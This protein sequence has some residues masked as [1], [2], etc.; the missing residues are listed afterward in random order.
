M[1]DIAKVSEVAIAN[2]AK[3]STV[4]IANV[5]SVDGAV[6]TT[7]VSW[8]DW[9]EASES[10]LAS[11]DTFV[12]LMEN[13]SAG[14]NETG[15]GGGL[16]G[17][18]LILTQVNNIPG[19]SGGFR[20]LTSG[21]QQRFDWTAAALNSLIKDQSEWTIVMKCKNLT[22]MTSSNRPIIQWR[23]GSTFLDITSDSVGTGKI[24]F[25]YN[26][27]DVTSTDVVPSSGN[28]YFCIWRKAG[29]VKAGFIATRPT[30]ESDFAASKTCEST[31]DAAYTTTFVNSYILGDTARW[32]NAFIAYIVVSKSAL[33]G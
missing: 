31:N 21:S 14:G 27:S 15:E 2:I 19:V 28:I 1:A 26:T 24:R 4:D 33:F 22:N 8:A 16:T 17:S 13:V 18:D 6:A 30:N 11:A 10:G 20:Q 9:D 23:V 3:I 25:L 5:N 32:T 29:A 12:C 7:T